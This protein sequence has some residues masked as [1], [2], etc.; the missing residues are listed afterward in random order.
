MSTLLVQKKIMSDYYKKDSKALEISQI[1]KRNISEEIRDL[2][3]YYTKK[4]QNIG[5]YWVKIVG[6]GR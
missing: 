6:H 4:S 1:L 3:A 2:T 5:F